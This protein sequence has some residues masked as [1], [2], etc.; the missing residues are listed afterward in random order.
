MVTA[1]GGKK[2]EGKLATGKGK[3]KLR[4]TRRPDIRVETRTKEDAVSGASTASLFPFSS[5]RSRLEQDGEVDPPEV[6]GKGL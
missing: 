5:E 1:C 6:S 3:G 4:M 2:A